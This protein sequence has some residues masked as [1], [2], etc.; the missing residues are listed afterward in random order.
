M[1]IHSAIYRY[2]S[3]ISTSG[4]VVTDGTEQ[5]II[6]LSFD[7]P[8]LVTMDT[9]TS[10]YTINVP[11]NGGNLSAIHLDLT[12]NLNASVESI[13][14]LPVE[15]PTDEFAFYRID[16]PYYIVSGGINPATKY[17]ATFEFSQIAAWRVGIRATQLDDSELWL[18]ISRGQC[19]EFCVHGFCNSDNAC[20]CYEGFKGEQCD[21]LIHTSSTSNEVAEQ[22]SIPLPEIIATIVAL[23]LIGVIIITIVAIVANYLNAKRKR[24][25][26]PDDTLFTMLAQE[27]DLDSL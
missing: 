4:S 14:L 18:T 17:N 7:E 15:C 2:V 9:W 21:I 24:N 26:I 27:Q 19:Q 3:Q 23:S 8:Q 13:A 16:I 20:T 1:Y 10:Y 25:I 6:P 22:S 12:G 11:W 5:R